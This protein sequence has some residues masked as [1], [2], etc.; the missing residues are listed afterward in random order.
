MLGKEQKHKGLY[1]LTHSLQLDCSMPQL[2]TK[3]DHTHTN[4]H[5]HAHTDTHTQRVGACVFGDLIKAVALN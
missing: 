2:G 4:V 1:N 3:R 5:T